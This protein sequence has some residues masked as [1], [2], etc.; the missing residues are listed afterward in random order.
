MRHLLTIIVVMF[1]LPNPVFAGVQFNV[2]PDCSKYLKKYHRKTGQDNFKICVAD[3]LGVVYDD[4]KNISITRTFDLDNTYI[5]KLEK[6]L[7]G[8]ACNKQ[9]DVYLVEPD[10]YALLGLKKR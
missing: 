7:L 2:I 9:W 1:Y 5:W 4:L 3:H 10:T 8:N 6:L